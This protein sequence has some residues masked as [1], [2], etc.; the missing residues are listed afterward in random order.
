MQEEVNQKA[1]ALTTNASK[2]TGRTLLKLVQMYIRHQKNKKLNPNFPQGKQ[3]VK[4]LAKQGQGMSSL[5]M[6]DKDVKLFDRVMKKYGVDYA[7]MSDKK[8]DPPSHTIF[9]KGKDADAV[10]KAFEEFTSNLTKKVSKPSVLSQLKQFAELV[11]NT[12]IDKVKHKEQT[13]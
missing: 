10:T 13:R 8:A 1:I 12:V 5:D 11:K 2:L 3:D 9:F 7:I 6:N 4:T